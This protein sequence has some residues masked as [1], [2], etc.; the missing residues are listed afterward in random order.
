[1]K[2]SLFNDSPQEE[3]SLL[4]ELHQENHTLATIAQEAFAVAQNIFPAAESVTEEADTSRQLLE[5]LTTQKS[6]GT[7]YDEATQEKEKQQLV[8]QELRHILRDTQLTDDAKLEA[9]ATLE[10][11][12]GNAIYVVALNTLLE[13]YS[14]LPIDRQA[15]LLTPEQ[16]ANLLRIDAE[17]EQRRSSDIEDIMHMIAT[18]IDEARI[19]DPVQKQDLLTK[20]SIIM[21][22]SSSVSVRKVCELEYQRLTNELAQLFLHTPAGRNWSA[23]KKMLRALQQSY[24]CVE[25]DSDLYKKHPQ[26][27][28]LVHTVEMCLHDRIDP[29]TKKDQHGLRSVIALHQFV[30]AK[31]RNAMANAIDNLPNQFSDPIDVAYDNAELA[32]LAQQITTTPKL[33][34]QYMQLLCSFYTNA[35]ITHSA[36]LPIRN[37]LPIRNKSDT[38]SGCD[39][40]SK[41]FTY[42]AW[43]QAIA[44][45]DDAVIRLGLL[46]DLVRMRDLVGVWADRQVVTAPPIDFPRFMEILWPKAREILAREFRTPEIPPQAEVQQLTVQELV[47]AYGL[48]ILKTHPDGMRLLTNHLAEALTWTSY[49]DAQI[50]AHGN[51]YTIKEKPGELEGILGDNHFYYGQSQGKRWM[52]LALDWSKKELGDLK[53]VTKVEIAWKYTLVHYEASGRYTTKIYANKQEIR[54]VTSKEEDQLQYIWC[55]ENRFPLFVVD[56]GDRSTQESVNQD[57]STFQLLKY[58]DIPQWAALFVL[59]DKEKPASKYDNILVKCP[60]ESSEKTSFMDMKWKEHLTLSTKIYHDS[61]DFHD[62]LAR[63]SKEVKKWIMTTFLFGF[64]DKEGKEVIPCMYDREGNFSEGKCAVRKDGVTSYI[65]HQNNL[66]CYPSE[67]ISEKGITSRDFQLQQAHPFVNDYARLEYRSQNYPPRFGDIIAPICLTR[68]INAKGERLRVPL[69]IQQA[70]DFRWGIAKVQLQDGSRGL[71]DTFGNF[72]EVHKVLPSWSNK[73]SS[74]KKPSAT[75]G[76]P[77]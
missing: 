15:T 45:A 39:A 32:S 41:L 42:P 64:I 3:S 14:A 29:T 34:G 17:I 67:V 47:T 63:V 13:Q 11:T 36:P 49:A 8:M 57:I 60:Y 26:L 54:A 48:D 25:L 1:M 76:W 5:S 12:A 27:D 44:Q 52:S 21:V 20:I 30:D 72:Y 61:W 55:V 7:L 19:A 31:H 35:M 58:V 56:R 65:D 69:A 59:L 2:Q 4:R 10:Q 75:D 38:K 51:V 24:T 28:Q 50:D 62:G 33:L 73:K 37:E 16:Y 74:A 68:F 77:K 66:V 40:T 71:I 53:E 23:T 43:M 18:M 46:T 6:F 9:I 22:L 70:S